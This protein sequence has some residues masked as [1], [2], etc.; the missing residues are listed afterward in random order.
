ME[1]AAEGKIR[2]GRRGRDICAC[3]CRRISHHAA[4][5]HAGFVVFHLGVDGEI[6]RDELA[7]ECGDPDWLAG[8]EESHV[9]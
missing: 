5:P 7:E 8:D 9:H 6:C 3:D 2:D 1:R 4:N